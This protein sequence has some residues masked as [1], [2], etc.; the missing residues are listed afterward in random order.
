MKVKTYRAATLREALNKVKRELGP[1]AFILGKREIRSKNML[2][3]AKSRVEVTAAIEL[4]GPANPSK[5]FQKRPLASSEAIDAISDRLH[6]S[7]TTVPSDSSP[8]PASNDQIV[9][10]EIRKLNAAIRSISTQISRPTYLSEITTSILFPGAR[11]NRQGTSAEDAK[12]SP[13]P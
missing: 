2:G 1:D 3:F 6:L 9:L 12:C 7:S 5:P 8:V 10:D 4:P 13:G 11:R